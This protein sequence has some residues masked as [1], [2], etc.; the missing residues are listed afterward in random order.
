MPIMPIL[1]QQLSNKIKEEQPYLVKRE[2]LSTQDNSPVYKSAIAMAKNHELGLK[3]VPHS[4]YLAFSD[5][6]LF[7][8][9]K[10]WF[11]SKRFS[12]NSE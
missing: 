2:V 6:H 3:L 7:P 4:P 11:G 1:L 8:N 10:Q 5:N 12:S 9:L